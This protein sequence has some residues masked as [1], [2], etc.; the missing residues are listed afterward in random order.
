[1]IALGA[2]TT[3]QEA[4]FV[5][6]DASKVRVRIVRE[7][8]LDP[9]MVAAATLGPNR[10]TN[11]V[12]ATLLARAYFHRHLGGCGGAEAPIDG[13]GVWTFPTRVGF[14]GASG[15]NIRIDKRTGTASANGLPTVTDPSV[16]Y[17][18]VLVKRRS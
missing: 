6:L 2:P 1:M 11:E 3:A 8:D 7:C 17:R 13:T 5:T 14:T 15:P 10:P 9:L 16:Y 4:P 18:F 12:R